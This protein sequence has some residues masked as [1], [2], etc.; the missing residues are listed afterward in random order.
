M[1]F[2]LKLIMQPTHPLR[3]VKRSNTC[4]SRITA[5]AGTSIGQRLNLSY[6]IIL[7]KLKV[8]RQKYAFLTY[9]T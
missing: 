2:H 6:V 1:K 9:M 7:L 3:P 5:A 8:L 4:A